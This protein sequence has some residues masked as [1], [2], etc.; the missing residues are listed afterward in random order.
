M[1]TELAKLRVFDEEEAD[2]HYFSEGFELTVD[3]KAG[4]KSWSADEAFLAALM[5]FAQANGSGS[6]YALWANGSKPLSL[7]CP[8]N[9]SQLHR[10]RSSSGPRSRQMIRMYGSHGRSN[11]TDRRT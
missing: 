11:T 6:F 8:S 9:L 10:M 2:G 4:L 7:E 3:D 1:P 5:P